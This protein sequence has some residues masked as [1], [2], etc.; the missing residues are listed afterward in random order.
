LNLNSKVVGLAICLWHV[1]KG[2]ERTD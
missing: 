1:A 2:F